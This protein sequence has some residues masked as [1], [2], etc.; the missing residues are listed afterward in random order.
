MIDPARVRTLVLFREFEIA[1]ISD[2]LTFLTLPT[3]QSVVQ[4]KVPFSHVFRISALTCSQSSPFFPGK[5]TLH[6]RGHCHR[7]DMYSLLYIFW[8]MSRIHPYFLTYN[9]CRQ[10]GLFH[11]SAP[12]PRVFHGYSLTFTHRMILTSE[13]TTL[14]TYLANI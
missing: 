2:L 1:H 5:S 12:S 4:A 7:M 13:R 14:G 10:C 3:S 11:M 9:K 8:F 6:T